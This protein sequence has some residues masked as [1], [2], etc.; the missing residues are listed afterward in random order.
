MSAE[1]FRMEKPELSM[2]CRMIADGLSLSKQTVWRTAKE[3][4][5]GR[6]KGGRKVLFNKEDT[7]TLIEAVKE[8]IARSQETRLETFLGNGKFRTSQV[9]AVNSAEM[10]S[11]SLAHNP[12]GRP[13]G[14]TN[15][16]KVVRMIIEA[17][18][19]GK[20]QGG[21]SK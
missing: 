20:K 3:V 15:E 8:R 14:S 9:E 7:E 10:N 2:T 17:Y 4:F 5:P 13:K 18:E 21:G 19:L 1:L 11:S 12:N 16:K 6:F